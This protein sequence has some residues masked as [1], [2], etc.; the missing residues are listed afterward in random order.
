MK[1]ANLDLLSNLIATTPPRPVHKDR[2]EFDAHFNDAVRKSDVPPP[3]S[4][5]GNGATKNAGDD[6]KIESADAS[7]KD[8]SDV[9]A[10]D[11][12]DT[13]IESA[14]ASPTPTKVK[15]KEK[16]D[17]KPAAKEEGDPE[18]AAA[19][20]G[21]SAVV[22]TQAEPTAADAEAEAAAQLAKQIA[23]KQA[24]IDAA[25]NARLNR[26]PVKP[27]VD[28]PESE[29][30]GEAVVKPEAKHAKQA[31]PIEKNASVKPE[32]TQTV[33]PAEDAAA[34][35]TLIKPQVKTQEKDTQVQ[36]PKD[37]PQVKAN[38]QEAAPVVTPAATKPVAEHAP[39]PDHDKDRKHD[40]RDSSRVLELKRAANE[41]SASIK[42]EAPTTTT[43][44]QASSVPSEV[45][46]T[47]ASHPAAD[48]TSAPPAHQTGVAAAS[49]HAAA[50]DADGLNDTRVTEQ[51]VRALKSVVN[52]K[53]GSVTLRLDP[54][55][56][57]ALRVRVQMDSGTVRA[58]FEAA[59]QS[60]RSA[61]EQQM[62]TLRHAL[63]S[64][65]LVVDHLHVHTPAAAPSQQ[66]FADQDNTPD[67]QSRGS[68][69]ENPGGQ[70]GGGE[71]RDGSGRQSNFER[72]LLDLVA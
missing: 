41:T 18:D 24:K 39:T 2:G 8:R 11:E 49:H 52:Q 62:S 70:G 16:A 13:E 1:L 54:P 64:H 43:P 42:I 34:T 58:T 56:L 50:S 9:D 3:K 69:G 31:A 55:E 4:K 6:T 37:A 26:G 5:S 29:T 12:P 28:K 72:E 68:F 46:A 65:G 63:E 45:L 40:S 61:L 35:A 47:T 32:V 21:A 53:G 23:A 17:E 38:A 22:T 27:A 15:A 19:V 48:A 59:N 57:G 60:V 44:V 20:A 10:T 67:G 14:D 71:A 7:P 30:R 25:A 66:S 36:A 51:A 33:K